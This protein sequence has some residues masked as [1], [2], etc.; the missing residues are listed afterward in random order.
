ML[1]IDSFSLDSIN[2]LFLVYSTFFITSLKDIKNEPYSFKFGHSS[3]FV[4]IM[5]LKNLVK[6]FFC[7]LKFIPL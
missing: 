5:I 4:F 7:K 6:V 1:E 3:F 2:D